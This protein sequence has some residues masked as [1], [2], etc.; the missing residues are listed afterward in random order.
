MGNRVRE[1]ITSESGTFVR[2]GEYKDVSG[3]VLT[4]LR[5]VP[6]LQMDKWR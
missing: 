3:G 6:K 2:L 4:C 1:I 5:Y